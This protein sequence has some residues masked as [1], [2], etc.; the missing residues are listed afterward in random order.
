MNIRITYTLT[1]IV[2]FCSIVYELLLAQTLSTVLGNTVVRYSLTIGFYLAAKGIGA[3][4]CN[5]K[6]RDAVKSLLK[7]GNSGQ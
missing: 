5:I 7:V 1:F 6:N 2:S 3:M 4:L